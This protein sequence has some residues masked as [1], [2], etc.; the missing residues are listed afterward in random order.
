[1]GAQVLIWGSF[2]VGSLLAIVAGVLCTEP[3][4]NGLRWLRRRVRRR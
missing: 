3:L 2:I 1:M 4:S